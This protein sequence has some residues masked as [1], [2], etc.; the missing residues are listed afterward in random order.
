MPGGRFD[1]YVPLDKVKDRLREFYADG[2]SDNQIEFSQ[3]QKDDEIRLQGYCLLREGDFVLYYS[4]DKTHIRQ[5]LL[6]SGKEISGYRA[7][8]Q[9]R[10]G[11]CPN[12]VEWLDY[13]LS[14]SGNNQTSPVV[15]FSTYTK[16]VG[17]LGWSTLFW[18]V[19]DY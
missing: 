17:L 6:N 11:M 12:S 13:L 8:L 10:E 18:E 4:K 1:P 7:L 16:P 3:M 5:A 9:A 14:W 15:E 19:R 2:Y